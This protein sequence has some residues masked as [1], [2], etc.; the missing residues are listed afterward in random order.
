MPRKTPEALRGQARTLA[1]AAAAAA[2]WFRRPEPA[3][4]SAARTARLR[5]RG[6]REGAVAALKGGRGPAK[7]DGADL[8]FALREAVES[9]VSA[10]SD[11]ALWGLG[12]DPEFAAAAESLRDGAKAL[13]RAAESAGP[14]RADALVEAKRWA[15]DVERR[16]RGE[17]EAARESSFFIDGVKRSEIATR[18]SASAEALQQACDALAGSLAE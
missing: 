11:A 14:T 13:A 12:A 17:L 15:A 6:W 8:S 2:R 10:V 1:D 4:L 18:L 7:T 16:R 3:A 9:A 5:A